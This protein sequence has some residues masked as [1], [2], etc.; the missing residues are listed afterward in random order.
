MHSHF[1]QVTDKGSNMLKACRLLKVL[2]FWCIGH[3]IH[4]LLMK[5]CFP[6][7]DG[8]AE[9]LDKIQQT[10]DK[11]RYRQQ[12]L[13][14]EFHRSNDEL[15]KRL[16]E[17]IGHVG[18]VLDADAASSPYN[19]HDSNETNENEKNCVPREIQ[20]FSH[21]Q[22][23]KESGQTPKECSALLFSQLTNS[24]RFQTLKKRILT[25]WNTILVML[26]SY[27]S[28][29]NGIE[30][31]LRRLKQYDL[32][33]TDVEIQMVAELVDFLSLFESTTTI[34]SASKSYSTM[35]LYLL[36]RMVSF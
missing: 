10:I 22:L 33:L 31:M 36:L 24:N 5:D 30:T 23:D 8:V 11:L 32:I 3:G 21:L 17:I 1:I 13:E 16:L 28:N 7:I 35:N 27:K 18:E 34:L 9:L 15:G 12:E 26:R 25:R 20:S 2:N 29:L 6:R 14:S 4:N 19:E